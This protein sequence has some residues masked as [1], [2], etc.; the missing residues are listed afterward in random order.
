MPGWRNKK[1]NNHYDLTVISDESVPMAAGIENASNM[2][3]AF[4]VILIAIVL[5]ALILYMKKCNQYRKRVQELQDQNSEDINRK[6]NSW[7]IHKLKLQVEYLENVAV[8]KI[9]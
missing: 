9:I 4:A 2:K 7:N 6:I 3:T 8:E 5:F 1:M